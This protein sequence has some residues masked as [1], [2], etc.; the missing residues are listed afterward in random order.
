MQKDQVRFAVIG[1]GLAA[2]AHAKELAHV[3][4]ARFAAVY[5]RDCAK[6]EQFRAR[7]QASKAYSSREEL[8][9][10]SEIDAVIIGTPNALH[11]EF[12]IAAAEAKKHVVVEKPLEI[13]SARGRDIIDA[14]NRH[15]VSLFVIYQMRYAEATAMLKE[16]IDDGALGKVILVNVLDNKYRTPG[17]YAKDYWRG[18]REFEGG[19]CL[20]TQTTHVLDLIQYLV[21]PVESAFA[22]V[23]TSVHDIETED[24][25]VATLKFRGGALG[26]LSSTTAVFPAQRHI[27]TVMGTNGTISINAEHDQVILRNIREGGTCIDAPGGF[28]F[29]D[30]V[31][32]VSFP[33]L[34]HRK[35]LQAIT[36]RIRAGRVSNDTEAEYLQALYLTDAIYRSA[37]EGREVS[38]EEFRSPSFCGRSFSSP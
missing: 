16:A 14:C 31:E 18:T 32:P 4:G 8:L 26:V 24:L 6:A 22:H 1:T 20:I 15:G 38:L 2:A 10:D 9:D 7:F 11:R 23:K 34:R 17:Y 35:Q 13:T 33:T 36:D 30:S 5:A 12:A 19:G 28:A 29:R 37:A 3:T 25:A 27:V 21:G